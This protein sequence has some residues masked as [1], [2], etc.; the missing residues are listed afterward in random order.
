MK[1]PKSKI[2]EAE[3]ADQ[4][5]PKGSEPENYTSAKEAKEVAVNLS[6]PHKHPD[7]LDKWNERLDHNLESEKE[8][9]PEADKHAA[10]YSKKYGSGDQTDEGKPILP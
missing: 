2:E 9:D 4:Q 8:G 5:K 10:D 6:E 3:T 1:T 7:G